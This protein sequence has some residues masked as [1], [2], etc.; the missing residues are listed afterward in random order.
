MEK[1]FLAIYVVLAGILLS[2]CV[3]QT[4]HPETKFSPNSPD[5]LVVMGVRT[6][7]PNRWIHRIQWWR[8]DPKTGSFAEDFD[9]VS[10]GWE[11]TD[12]FTDRSKTRYMIFRVPAGK[13]GLESFTSD[14]KFS[15]NHMQLRPDTLAFDVEAAEI[16]YIGEYLIVIPD[17][18]FWK[19][20]RGTIIRFNGRNDQAAQRSLK[21]YSGIKGRIKF[22]KPGSYKLN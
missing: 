12:Y 2:G 5:S 21:G 19:S 15:I 6:S 22:I 17:R 3:D 8:I 14:A 11:P 20:P 7:V 16:A 9:P 18:G 10:L 4:I 1:K 13:Y